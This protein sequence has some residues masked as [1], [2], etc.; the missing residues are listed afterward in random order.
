[1]IAIA[2]GYFDTLQLNDGTLFTSFT[3]HCNRVENGMQT[4]NNP[5]VI[6]SYDITR[7]G[8]EEQFRKGQ[9]VY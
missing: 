2:D 8:C 9:F 5:G 1:M 3:E 4:T 6:A 7:F